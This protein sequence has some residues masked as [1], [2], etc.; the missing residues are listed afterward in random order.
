MGIH[1][2]IQQMDNVVRQLVIEKFLNIDIVKQKSN[3][4]EDVIQTEVILKERVTDEKI[5]RDKQSS[6]KYKITK[7]KIDRVFYFS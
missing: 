3:L 1:D 2:D 7:S 5:G 4:S 6:I